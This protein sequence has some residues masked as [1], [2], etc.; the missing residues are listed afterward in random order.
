MEAPPSIRPADIVTGSPVGAGVI[1]AG[2][3][4]TAGAGVLADRE[5][6]PA[7]KAAAKNRDRSKKGG[8]TDRMVHL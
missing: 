1:G 7:K 4:G 8:R 3:D 5:D 2:T 6:R